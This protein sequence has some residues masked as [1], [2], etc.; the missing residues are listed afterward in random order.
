MKD[1]LWFFSSKNRQSLKC[2]IWSEI[3]VYEVKYAFK[4]VKDKLEYKKNKIQINFSLG[5]FWNRIETLQYKIVR[6]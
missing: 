1:F 6:I 4:F 5:W 3:E 2:D